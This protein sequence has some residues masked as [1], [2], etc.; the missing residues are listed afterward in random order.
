VL[1]GRHDDVAREPSIPSARRTRPTR[2]RG[3]DGDWI[4]VEV[5]LG[6]RGDDRLQCAREGGLLERLDGTPVVMAA[7]SH[8]CRIRPMRGPSLGPPVAL[9]HTR[10]CHRHTCVMLV[11]GGI[12]LQNL[13]ST[14]LWAA[15]G[16]KD[17]LAKVDR[18]RWPRLRQALVLLMAPTV[19]TASALAAPP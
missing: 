12:Y 9:R 13:W 14:L 6:L 18:E 16:F 10:D 1:L 5:G 2:G 15:E 19:I 7:L 11:I 3:G 17:A 4:A 8:G